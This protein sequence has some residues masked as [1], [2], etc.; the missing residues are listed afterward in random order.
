MKP[1][2]RSTHPIGKLSC[3]PIHPSHAAGPRALP[4]ASACLCMTDACMRVRVLFYLLLFYTFFFSFLDAFAPRTTCVR[5]DDA[6]PGREEGGRNRRPEGRGGGV[7]AGNT[8]FFPRVSAGA[9]ESRPS[10]ITW[11]FSTAIK[12]KKK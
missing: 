4:A 6:V 5:S 8:L 11:M 2:K 1:S 10:S 12:K 9:R 3:P 7:V